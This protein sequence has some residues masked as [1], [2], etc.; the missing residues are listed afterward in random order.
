M[1]TCIVFVLGAKAA[2]GD[3]SP[4]DSMP[5]GNRNRRVSGAI[6][7][8]WER[9][10]G[11]LAGACWGPQGLTSSAEV[12]WLFVCSFLFLGS[13][14]PCASRRFFETLSEDAS[15]HCARPSGE[16]WVFQ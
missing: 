11:F 2:S 4:A 13:V 8:T 10:Q 12:L 3:G 16:D 5:A 15:L 1:P 6:K 14:F 7:S 9:N